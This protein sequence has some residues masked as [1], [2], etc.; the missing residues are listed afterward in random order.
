[1]VYP[2]FFMSYKKTKENTTFFLGFLNFYIFIFVNNPFL[3]V[4][5]FMNTNF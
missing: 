5:W 2:P 3:W 4:Y 1:V